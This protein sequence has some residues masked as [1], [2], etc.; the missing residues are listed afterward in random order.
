MLMTINE[1]NLPFRFMSSYLLEG[2]E[3]LIFQP[4]STRKGVRPKENSSN[5]LTRKQERLGVTNGLTTETR[6]A[7]RFVS[8]L[9]AIWVSAVEL[10]VL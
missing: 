2:V 8:F 5:T 10:S 9:R 3:L 6:R 1:T 4:Y 7:Q